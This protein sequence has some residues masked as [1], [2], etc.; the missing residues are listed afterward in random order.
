[1]STNLA[2]HSSWIKTSILYWQLPFLSAFGDEF[3]INPFLC[4]SVHPLSSYSFIC[5]FYHPPIPYPSIHPSTVAFSLRPSTQFFINLLAGFIQIHCQQNLKRCPLWVPGQSSFF[6]AV[7]PEHWRSLRRHMYVCLVDNKSSPSCN[8]PHAQML[9]VTIAF[10]RFSFDVLL[11]TRRS[12]LSSQMHK[13][14]FCKCLFSRLVWWRLDEAEQQ[15]VWR[16]G[17]INSVNCS[18]RQSCRL[19]GGKKRTISLHIWHKKAGS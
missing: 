1:M 4:P 18:L 16:C 3:T 5:S 10:Y 6:I 13:P 7:L 19:L 9:T 14:P 8:R 15:Q 17:A 12:H 11:C 2:G